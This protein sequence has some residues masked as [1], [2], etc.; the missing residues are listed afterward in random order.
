MLLVDA[1]TPHNKILYNVCWPSRHKIEVDRLRGSG[2]HFSYVFERKIELVYMH[3][4]PIF[5]LTTSK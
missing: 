1:K 4:K 3:T 5:S 2:Q